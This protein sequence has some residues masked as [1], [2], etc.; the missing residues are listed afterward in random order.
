MI[1]N[2][3]QYIDMCIFQ[4]LFQLN[5]LLTQNVVCCSRNQ[6]SII[7][8]FLAQSFIY[9]SKQK[10]KKPFF[11]IEKLAEQQQDFTRQK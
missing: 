3:F 9:F 2:M 8:L 4:L 11:K 6:S 7:S 10:K 1:M 5:R